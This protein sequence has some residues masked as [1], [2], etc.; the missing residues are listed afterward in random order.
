MCTCEICLNNSQLRSF[1]TGDEGKTSLLIGNGVLKSHPGYPNLDIQTV[2]DE[3][4]AKLSTLKEEF[5]EIDCPETLL[6]ISRVYLS[7]IIFKKYKEIFKNFEPN[8]KSIR[9]F[10][11]PYRNL[12]T[13]NYDPITYK[14]IFFKGDISFKDGFFSKG[15]P[16]SIEK[17][18]QNINEEKSILYIHGAFHI[19]Y[20]YDPNYESK[21]RYSKILKIDGKLIDAIGSKQ[22]DIMDTWECR[23][24]NRESQCDEPYKDIF[25]VID[26]RS[27][28]KKAWIERDPYLSFCLQR[29]G[30]Q[31]RVRALGCAFKMDDHILEAILLN[32]DLESLEIGIY[33]GD[34]KHEA[35]N[36]ENLCQTY[37]RII[38]SYQVKCEGFLEGV[39]ALCN[40]CAYRVKN[41]NV[42]FTYRCVPESC[43]MKKIDL[44]KK[45]AG[46]I[47]LFSAKDLGS[48]IWV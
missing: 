46:K 12:F 33:D 21:H 15:E 6:N 44:I 24:K 25:C 41:P 32:E 11:S 9:E 34:S 29:L 37:K 43:V 38:D 10:V 26:S 47:S 18:K 19:L 3:Y 17:L 8:Q 36:R 2:V 13:L 42:E 35:S 28:Y 45:N 23:W 39:P 31:E 22:Q 20:H 4:V 48:K 27:I 16:L 7:F 40:A 5:R 30:K 1:P 14:S